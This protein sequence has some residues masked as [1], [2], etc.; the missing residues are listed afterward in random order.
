[1]HRE[2]ADVAD[3]TYA[4]VSAQIFVMHSVLRLTVLV[5]MIKPSVYLPVD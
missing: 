3:E 1:M 5:R 4:T 2:E